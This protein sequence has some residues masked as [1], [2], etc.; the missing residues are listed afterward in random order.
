MRHTKRCPR[1][2]WKK[3]D[4]TDSFCKDCGTKITIVEETKFGKALRY[5]EEILEDEH[6]ISHTRYN[7][8]KKVLQDQIKQTKE[9]RG[10]EG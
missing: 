5:L 2:G 6:R 10:D 8:I 7:F 1:C 4:I 3:K 9:N